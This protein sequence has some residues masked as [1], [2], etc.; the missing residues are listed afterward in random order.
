[1]A[2][3]PAELEGRAEQ[4]G[5]QRPL[6]V[7]WV[8]PR[9]A[10]LSLAAAAEA[11]AA[12]A[13]IEQ[14]DLDRDLARLAAHELAPTKVLHVSGVALPELRA[15]RHEGAYDVL[16]AD[17]SDVDTVPS[18]ADAR[19]LAGANLLL[20]GS[21]AALREIRRR[22]P[23]LATRTALF[24]IPVD[25]ASQDAVP[26]AG[27]RGDIVLFAGPLTAGGGL[28][29]VVEALAQLDEPPAVQVLASGKPEQRY[30]TWCQR[31]AAAAGIP[32]TIVGDRDGAVEAAYA[33]ATLVCVPYRDPIGGD[34]ARHAA[35]A[36]IPIVGTEVEPLLEV[37]E[38][39]GTGYL[40]PID[41]IGQLAHRIDTLVRDAE[42]SRV[43]GRRAR[44]RAEA[45][46]SPSAAVSRL[47]SLWSEAAA[48]GLRT[49]LAS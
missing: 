41:D 22:Y 11:L 19:R 34:A 46:L 44:E 26:R 29:L 36:A 32:L 9:P 40:V 15:L 13:V 21:V 3:N 30:L 31:R 4:I 1:M 25:F 39:G 17:L 28:D 42:L 45:E 5:R 43:F 8:G 18:R 2:L 35:A 20:V 24:R 14:D 47:V 6:T 7:E 10:W 48:R 33:S 16:A 12:Y 23:F 38:D 49:S 27:R 37:V